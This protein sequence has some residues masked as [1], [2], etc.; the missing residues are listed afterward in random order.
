MSAVPLSRDGEACIV[1]AKDY[2][3][4][5]FQLTQYGIRPTEPGVSYA[6]S[7]DEAYTLS[8]GL[9]ADTPWCYVPDGVS[10]ATVGFMR[11]IFGPEKAIADAL[12]V[13][14]REYAIRPEVLQRAGV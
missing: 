9:P 11:Q 8:M 6:F 10:M 12:N 1:I 7:V 4:L 14:N 3:T 5:A 13:Q 2:D